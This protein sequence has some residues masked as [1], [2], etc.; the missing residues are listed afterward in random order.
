VAEVSFVGG[1]RVGWVNATWPF[2][3]LA[4]SADRLTISSLGRYDFAPSQVISLERYGSIPLF[5][6]G[7]RVKH[8]RSDYPEKI[9]F[10]CLGN[11]DAVLSEI[12]SVGFVP[13]GQAG[14]RASGFPV[15]WTAAL[16][17]IAAWNALFLLDGS[18]RADAPKQPGSL[19][20][21]ALLLVLLFSTSVQ[22][23][24][25]MQRLV[26]R[27]DHQIGEIK[28]FLMLLQIVSGILSLVFGIGLLA[29]LYAP[30]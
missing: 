5:Y 22:M 10:W 29:H 14:T 18:Y 20:F 19:A 3:K 26:L 27:K 11:T 15:K 4:V 9:I 8:N 21:L 12:R 1:A 13:N 25:S 24:A 23:S 2:A 28:A 30:K 7:V 6:S 17:V 16:A